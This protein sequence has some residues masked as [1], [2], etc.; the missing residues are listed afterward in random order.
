MEATNKF[1]ILLILATI[2]CSGSAFAQDVPA[3]GI[4]AGVNISNIYDTKGEDLSDEYKVD[5]AGGAFLSIP[6][7][8]VVGL[9]PEVMYSKK[10]Y[11]GSGFITTVGYKYTRTFDYLDVP[12][13]LQIKPSENITLVAGPFFSWLLHKR[14]EIKDGSISVEQQTQIKN[15]NIRKNTFGVTGGLD[16]I[17]HP[18][19][20][21]GRVGFDLRDN[22][23]DGT[24]TDPRF[25]NTWF[26]ATVGV[27]F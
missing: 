3:F 18:V 16:V 24:S 17:L 14:V 20:L 26:Q 22:N 25:K 4:K 5:F 10:G 23:G 8:T 9:Q 27:V 7:G 2:L 6:F 1:K 21:S 15:S 12:I 11:R 19:V 13:L